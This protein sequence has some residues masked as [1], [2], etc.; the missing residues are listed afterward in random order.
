MR[1]IQCAENLGKVSSRQMSLAL[2]VT[3]E[4]VLYKLGNELIELSTLVNSNEDH[5]E[6][7]Y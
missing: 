2:P 6:S 7:V 3:V 4:Y 5:I 1:E